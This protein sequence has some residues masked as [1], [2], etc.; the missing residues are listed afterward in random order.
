MQLLMGWAE[1]SKRDWK[2]STFLKEQE[3]IGAFWDLEEAKEK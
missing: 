1:Q 2:P 3:C